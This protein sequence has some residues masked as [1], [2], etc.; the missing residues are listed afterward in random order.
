VRKIVRRQTACLSQPTSSK[1]A[2]A[3]LK[4]VTANALWWDWVR[5]ETLRGDVAKALE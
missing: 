4:L 5:G 2:S 3:M 1:N